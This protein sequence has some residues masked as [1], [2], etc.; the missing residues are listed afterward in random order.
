M[1]FIPTTT[2]TF[3]VTGTDLNGCTNTS[4]RT[5][6]VNPIPSVGSNA[7][8][9]AVCSGGSVILTGTGAHSYTWSNG[10]SNGVAFIPT[11]TTTFTVTGTD[12][13]GCTNT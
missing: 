4:T 3:T 6:V 9:N 13:N 8:A 11:T 2:T 12:L 7:S 5:I 1:A 10:V